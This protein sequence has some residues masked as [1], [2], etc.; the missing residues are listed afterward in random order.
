MPFS[1]MELR[2]PPASPA[3]SAPSMYG[4]GIVFHPPS[5]SALA[6]YRTSLTAFQ[7]LR[8]ERMLLEP[9]ERHVRVEQR[10]LVVEPDD[11]TDGQLSIGH[12]VDEA[13]AELL[14]PQRIAHANGS[15]CPVRDG[16]AALP[17][18]P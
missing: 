11:E 8:H 10:V 9:I 13:A 7:Q 5:G 14:V 17:T 2:N 15:R 3:M 1:R 16:R 4:C 6:P 18:T 12:R